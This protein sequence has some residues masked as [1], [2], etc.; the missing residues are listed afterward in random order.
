MD[1]IPFIP[2][3]I[4]CNPFFSCKIDCIRTS[5]YTPN[6]VR[7]QNLIAGC[8]Y[9]QYTPNGVNGHLNDAGE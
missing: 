2:D 9:Q 8:F 6:G 7:G 5:Q 1:K 3:Y 4:N